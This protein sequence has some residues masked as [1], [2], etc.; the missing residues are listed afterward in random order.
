MIRFRRILVPH[1]FSDSATSALKFAA[2]LVPPDGRLSVLHVIVAFVPVTDIPPAGIGGYIAP[3][4]LVAGARR[5]LDRAITRR[6]A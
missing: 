1:D 4:E 6:S 5:Q 3:T 2:G